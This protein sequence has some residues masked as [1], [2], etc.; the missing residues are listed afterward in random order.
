MSVKTGWNLCM[1]DERTRCLDAGEIVG[2][3]RFVNVSE[4]VESCEVKC[5]K[6]RTVY[7][8]VRLLL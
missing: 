3:E 7:F 1:D 2:I 4:K 8:S 6:K 5:L